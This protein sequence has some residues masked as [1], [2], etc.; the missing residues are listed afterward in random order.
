MKQ[1]KNKNYLPVISC[2]NGRQRD[3]VDNF[4]LMS[5]LSRRLADVIRLFY[6]CLSRRHRHSPKY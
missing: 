2:G 3:G 1:N 4:I 5:L 6:R